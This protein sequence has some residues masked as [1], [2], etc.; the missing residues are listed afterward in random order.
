MS[1]SILPRGRT[2]LD[3]FWDYLRTGQYLRV[4]SAVGGGS[5]A[6]SAT[7]YTVPAGKRAFVVALIISGGPTS[8]TTNPNGRVSV[9]RADGTVLPLAY[10]GHLL[11][12][13]GATYHF[14]VAV[15]DI[16]VLEEGDSI[17]VDTT[18]Y[19]IVVVHAII[20]EVSK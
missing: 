15:E 17:R 19:F 18:A 1:V 3:L 13:S 10:F 4:A 20:V 5:A 8:T 14:P 7:L 6:T 12:T 9:V 16:V 11:A 2:K